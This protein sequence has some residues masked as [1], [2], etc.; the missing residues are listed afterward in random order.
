MKFFSAHRRVWPIAVFFTFGLLLFLVAFFNSTSPIISAPTK[1]ASPALNIIA[2]VSPTAV[3]SPSPT[4]LAA[5]SNQGTPQITPP[6]Q[7]GDEYLALG[8]SVAYG[9]GAP[10][11]EQLGYAGIFYDNYLRRVQP[12]LLTYKNFAVPG[13]TSTSFITRT[14]N[15]SQLDRTLQELDAADKAG[16]R[17]SPITLTIGGN[18]MLDAR[19]KSADEKNAVLESYDANLQKILATLTER[20]AGKSDI[21]LTTYYNPYAYAT[22]GQDEET[23]WVRRFNDTIRKRAAEYKVKLADFFSPIFGREKTFTWIGQGDIHPNTPGHALLASVVWQ[24]TGYDTLPPTLSLSASTLPQDRKLLAG[25]RFAL[26]LSVIHNPPLLLNPDNSSGAGQ[27]S[28]ASVSLDGSSKNR[29]PT[30]PAQYNKGPAGS[31]EFSY[32]LDTAGLTPGNHIL[33]FEAVDSAGNTGTFELSF[34]II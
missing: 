20:T 9:V 23:A 2:Q 14:R 26:K 7:V 17:I 25:Q 27:I 19:D 29:L 15:L 4:P 1:T 12:D 13:E 34:E 28:G 30:V 31:Q 33:K 32:I 18:D 24:A 5:Q 21:I 22:N 8:D 6:P 11:P 10:F 16:R 3:P